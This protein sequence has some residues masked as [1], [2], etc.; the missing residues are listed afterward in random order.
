MSHWAKF[1]EAL[2]AVM[3]LA[4]LFVFNAPSAASAQQ[5]GAPQSSIL[6]IS[7]ERLFNDSAFGRRVARE[8][9]A[10]SAVLAAE[11]RKIEADLGAEELDLTDRRLTMEPE[12]FRVLAEAFDKKVQQI[13]QTQEAKNRELA[14]F[15]DGARIEFL[16]AAGPILEA[17]MRESGAGVILERSSVFLSSN[18]TDITDLSIER[19]DQILGDGSPNDAQG[20]D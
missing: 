8:L 3:A 15:R 18:T 7:S 1:S 17:L 13:R 5:L 2:V 16:N 20:E 4:L 19:I 6:T 11:N 12:A 9:D 10:Q 14:S